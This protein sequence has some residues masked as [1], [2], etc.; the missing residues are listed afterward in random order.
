[1]SVLHLSVHVKNQGVRCARIAFRGRK[2]GIRRK[3]GVFVQLCWPK[4]ATLEKKTEDVLGNE[5]IDICVVFIGV[6]LDQDISVVL[7]AG[8]VVKLSRHYWFAIPFH[9]SVCLQMISS[10][11]QL[12]CVEERTERENVFD[13]NRVS[14]SVRMD[15]SVSLVII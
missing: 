11:D 5:P 10:R 7:V 13:D 14:L 6:F 8:N 3:N 12:L 15:D 9:L 4:K 2:V 1:M